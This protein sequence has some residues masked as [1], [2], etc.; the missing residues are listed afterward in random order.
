MSSASLGDLLLMQNADALTGSQAGPPP[1]GGTWPQSGQLRPAAQERAFPGSPGQ[2]AGRAS[3]GKPV[4]PQGV[5]RA[6]VEAAETQMRNDIDDLRRDVRSLRVSLQ[7]LPS[8]EQLMEEIRAQDNSENVMR[9]LT[10]KFEEAVARETVALR[11]DNADLRSSLTEALRLLSEERKDRQHDSHEGDKRLRD[12]QSWAEERIHRVE[13]LAKGVQS[14]TGDNKTQLQEIEQLVKLSEFRVMN[15]VTEEARSREAQLQREQQQREAAASDLESRWKQLFGEERQSRVRDQDALNGSLARIED[16]ARS[17]RETHFRRLAEVVAKVEDTTVEIREEARQR[18]SEVQQVSAQV[19]ELRGG[20]TTEGQERRDMHEEHGKRAESMKSNLEQQIVRLDKDLIA[21][22]QSFLDNRAAVQLET[23]NREEAITRLHSLLSDESRARE[24]GVRHAHRVSAD[25]AVEQQMKTIIHEERSMRENALGQLEAK[26][27]ALQHEHNFDKAKAL[28]QVRELSTTL[29]QAREALQA[30]AAARRQE[31]T[32]ASQTFGS[33]KDGLEQEKTSREKTVARLVE[34]MTVVEAA[35]RNETAARETVQRR[36]LGVASEVEDDHARI[37]RLQDDMDHRILPRLDEERKLREGAGFQEK[38]EREHDIAAV[39]AK[40]QE[41]LEAERTERGAQLEQLQQTLHN[42][43]Q[44]QSNERADRERNER[45]AQSRFGELGEEVLEARQRIRESASQCAELMRL[46]DQLLDERTNRQAE[47]T[48]LQLT[49]KEQQVKLDHLLQDHEQATRRH[50]ERIQEVHGKIESE[51]ADRKQLQGHLLATTQSSQQ[52]L[53]AAQKALHRQLEELVSQHCAD[54]NTRLEEHQV[55]HHAAVGALDAKSVELRDA[56]DEV[57]QWRS[58]QY[59][60]LVHELGKVAEMLAEEAKARQQQ[61]SWIASEVSRVRDELGEE[62]S[63]RKLAVTG[64]EE[65]LRGVLTRLEQLREASTE[66]EREAGRAVEALRAEAANEG[67]RRDALVDAL[68]TQ[69]EKDALIRDEVLAGATRAWQKANQR[70]NE[71]WRQA[72]RAEAQLTEQAQQRLELQV[73]DV[74]GSQQD[75]RVSLDAVQEDMKRRLQAA[76]DAVSAEEKTRKAEDVI[77]QR[78]LEDV[79]KSVSAEQAE[80]SGG[81]QHTADRFQVMENQLRE[82]TGAREEGERRL[83]KENLELQARLQAEQAAREEQL[84]QMHGQVEKQHEVLH[85]E[86]L[87]ETKQRQQ[88]NAGL[89]EAVQKALTETEEAL[90]KGRKDLMTSIQQVQREQKVEME[91]R[92]KADRD[93]AVTCTKLQAQLKE[94]EESRVEQGDRL[95]AGFENLQDTM[96]SL[97]QQREDLTR[98]CNQSL[99]EVRASLHKEV[100]ARTAKLENFDEIVRDVGRRIK[101]ETQQREVA[102]KAVLDEVSKEREQREDALPRMRRMAE[103]E[104]QRALQSTRRAREEEQRRLQDRMLEVTTAVSEQRDQLHEGL[105]LQQQKVADAKEELQRE[106]KAV[107]REVAKS[108]MQMSRHGEE[109]TS[110]CNSIEQIAADAQRLQEALRRDVTADGHRRDSQMQG[111]EQ[112]S[113]ELQRV[114]AS[115]QKQLQDG[116]VEL[117]RHVDEELASMSAGLVADR[118]AREA[119]D[120]QVHATLKEAMRVEV[121]VRDA[122]LAASSAELS[123]MKRTLEEDLAK[124]SD[125]KSL[126]QL[127]LQKLRADLQEMQGERKVDIVAIRDALAQVSEELKGQHRGRQEDNDR[128]DAALLNQTV[129]SDGQERKLKEHLFALEQQLLSLQSEV[130]QQGEAATST[131]AKT[132]AK[133]SEERRHLEA[134]LAAEASARADALRDAAEAQQQRVA[135]ETRKTRLQTEKLSVAVASLADDL[136]KE[137]TLS[138][139]RS[140]DLARG[141][142]ALQNLCSGEEQARQQSTFDLQQGIE[143]VREEL[144]SEAKERRAQAVKLHDDTQA[145][146]RQLQ[147]GDTRVE[148]LQKRLADD[149]ADLR[150]QLAREVRSRE[151]VI[152]QLDHRMNVSPVARSGDS[153]RMFAPFDAAGGSTTGNLQSNE[154]RELRNQTAED[155]SKQRRQLESQAAEQAVLAKS[156]G[157][158]ASQCEAVRASLVAVQSQVSDLATKK[159]AWENTV[160]TSETEQL[161]LRRER[162]ERKAED[163]RLMKSITDT[164]L[165]IERVEQG[166]LV[167]EDSIRQE[168]LN[169]KSL[170]RQQL[171]DQAVE[172]EKVQAALRHE[173]DQREEALQRE[174]RARQ[175]GQEQLRDQMNSAIRTERETRGKEVLRLEGRQTS[176]AGKALGGGAVAEFQVGDRNALGVMEVDVKSLRQALGDTQDR[177]V[178]VEVRQKSAEERTVSMLDAIMSGLMHPGE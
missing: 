175:E 169:T 176:I 107:E 35:L 51:L 90:E 10:A 30:E 144:L 104:L 19:E 18:Q 125:D 173:A 132:E 99:D 101:E 43:E 60:E 117:Q 109:M 80:R 89:Q 86:V 158:V 59:N 24:E 124:R 171:R 97:G 58:E 113:L 15:A 81:E 98:H 39:L 2:A 26:L 44:L 50:D 153:A 56:V 138:G 136:T 142:A 140:R 8:R 23:V 94:E 66:K 76:S 154:V 131:A 118:R 85:N 71:E 33:L 152:Q 133:A 147:L 16:T 22:K 135:E 45:S 163:E 53:E 34:Q 3:S 49:M 41:L 38:H 88:A 93:L 145:L 62:V 151:A 52:E 67:V 110:R 21:L 82:E 168:V 69:V 79:R 139:E 174:A 47:E 57:R 100:I 46:R 130:Q 12:V 20:L 116:V 77:L 105:R 48:A 6:A 25:G 13:T 28:A 42:M 177:L 119:G 120:I 123:H 149:A 137:R 129:K 148:A 70:S 164:E 65:Q 11:A 72:I 111:F 122:A 37:T 64:V 75:L 5:A 14:N 166:R 68:K 32:V 141:V 128:I 108:F 4:T 165:R 73:A 172:T 134:A 115:A 162:M 31:S 91:E 155:F 106:V 63:G 83:A 146:C 143:K 160:A 84:L 87:Q 126:T 103:E 150:E 157:S 170:V 55:K 29:T 1:D 156:V 96:R 178:A 74:K 121:D 7:D 112:Q 92:I 161:D 40:A 167:A 114:I 102:V 159:K 78:S 127:T 36:L 17:E 61:D 54:V 27:A 9:Q 95:S